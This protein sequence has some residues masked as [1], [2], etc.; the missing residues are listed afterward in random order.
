M[1]TT[2]TL[3]L[4]RNAAFSVPLAVLLGALWGAEHAVAAAVSSGVMLANFWALSLLGP[5]V[6][7]SLARGRDAVPWVGLLGLK[8]L[9]VCGVLL[10]LVRVFPPVG[11][12]LGF[13]P[14][15]VGV[16]VTGIMA[17][18]EEAAREA[19]EADLSPNPLDPETR[20]A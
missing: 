7:A 17:A 16:L 10:G 12:A 5:R 14:L 18:Q 13:V 2:T 19:A 11:V 15:V 20:E 4:L 3:P 1:T 9:V 8:F 6:V